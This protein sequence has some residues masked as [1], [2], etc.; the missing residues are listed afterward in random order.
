MRMVGMILNAIPQEDLVVHLYT[1]DRDPDAYREDEVREYVEMDGM[2][3]RPKVLKGSSWSLLAGPPPRGMYAEQS[4]V[5]TGGRRQLIH[6]YFCTWEQTGILA[7]A[8]MFKS[9]GKPDPRLIRVNNDEIRVIPKFAL[10]QEV[11]S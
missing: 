3:Y 9:E 8:E 10:R 11:Y 6:G 4:W 1:N 5:F 7:W 2:G